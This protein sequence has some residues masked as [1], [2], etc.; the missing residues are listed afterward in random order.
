MVKLLLLLVVHV[1][2]MAQVVDC[3]KIFEER[4]DEL[5]RE[6]ELIDEARQSFEALKAA[7][8]ALFTKKEEDMALQQAQ[9]D[10]KLAQ[11]N[12]LELQ[13]KKQIEA[14]N[15]LL[16]TIENKKNDKIKDTY[17]KMKDAS[18][19]SILESL[20]REEA[21]SILFSLAP[22]KVSAIM[23][24]MNPVVASEITVLLT[25]GPPFEKA[26]E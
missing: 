24:K 14:N 8:N 2:V 12:E 20:E 15:A 17:A 11:I 7:T 4:K 1:G 5:V 23:S 9:L 25:K 13:V 3:T 6:V 10:A 26:V 21:A 18:A 22:K 16:A 19:A